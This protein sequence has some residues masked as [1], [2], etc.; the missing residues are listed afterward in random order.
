MEKKYYRIID[1]KYSK[2]VRTLM[3][4]QTQ[5]FDDHFDS[6]YQENGWNFE[7]HLENGKNKHPKNSIGK[8]LE[9]A[10]VLDLWF[11]EVDK[12]N[13]KQKVLAGYRMKSI[14]RKIPT[15]VKSALKID[16]Y[17]GFGEAIKEG[18]VISLSS[19]GTINRLK[20]AGIFKLWFE[21]VYEYKYPLPEIEGYK[22][23][24]DET[25]ETITYGC[26]N[27]SKVHFESI[28]FKNAQHIELSIDGR[29]IS[30]QGKKLQQLKDFFKK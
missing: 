7:I 3:G 1:K 20:D 27:V 23:K 28:F 4:N 6:N 30:L 29:T 24:W 12:D 25:S 13:S 2:A 11:E 18:Q 26:T 16:G 9:D 15:V 5:W 8:K 17:V 22:G 21:P 14:Y 19:T 10:G